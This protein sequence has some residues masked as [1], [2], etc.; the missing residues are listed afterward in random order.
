MSMLHPTCQ[1]VE[2]TKHTAVKSGRYKP[3]EKKRLGALFNP[4][5][6]FIRYRRFCLVVTYSDVLTYSHITC[7]G[8]ASVSNCD[9]R[10]VQCTAFNT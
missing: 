2:Q 10:R 1:H 6:L 8:A 7:L 9:F 3:L 4:K 5:L